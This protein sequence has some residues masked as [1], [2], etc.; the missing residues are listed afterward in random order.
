MAELA[1]PVQQKAEQEVV[2]TVETAML[3]LSKIAFT[4]LGDGAVK[5]QC[6][7]VHH[8]Q[9]G[10]AADARDWGDIADEIVVEMADVAAGA[11]PIVDDE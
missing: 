4:E 7:G 3:K 8:H 11:R 1:A 10:L 9:V 6:R 5:C 2:A